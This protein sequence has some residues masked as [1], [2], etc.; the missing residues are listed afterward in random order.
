MS[1]FIMSQLLRCEILRIQE[2]MYLTFNYLYEFR[3]VWSSLNQ[4]HQYFLPIFF[5]NLKL[6][7][8]TQ[9][10]RSF[11][12]KTKKIKHLQKC[13]SKD[14]FSLSPFNKTDAK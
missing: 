14:I 9:N 1:T 3:F 8:V 4:L 13:K 6:T 7:L 10:K 11:E 2:R 12:D 5:I